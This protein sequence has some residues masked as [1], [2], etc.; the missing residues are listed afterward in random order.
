MSRRN[1]E[2]I[3]HIDETLSIPDITDLENSLS[4]DH[5]I[6][7]VHINRTRQHLMLIDFSPE[8]VTSVEV[9]NYVKNK[10]VHA[11]LIGGI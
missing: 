7:K 4:A 8:N 11:E 6:E 1:I 10:G 2:V 5:G 3:V 9:L